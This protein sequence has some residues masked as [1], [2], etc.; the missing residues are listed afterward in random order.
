MAFYSSRL[1][2]CCSGLAI[3][4]RVIDKLLIIIY[5][6]QLLFVAN[7]QLKQITQNHMTL[8]YPML[9]YTGLTTINCCYGISYHRCK[10]VWSVLTA[11]LNMYLHY[12]IP[13]VKSA[14]SATIVEISF[15]HVFI[16]IQIIMITTIHSNSNNRWHKH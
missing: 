8:T 15:F 4:K 14:V 11:I 2:L 1:V 6:S 5:V 12:Q 9:F 7:S 16:M 3:H 10:R 13:Y